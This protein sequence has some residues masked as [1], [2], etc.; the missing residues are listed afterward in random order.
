M[1]HVTTVDLAT[2]Q[3]DSIVND[4][5]FAD[6]GA[7]DF[8]VYMKRRTGIACRESLLLATELDGQYQKVANEWRFAS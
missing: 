2:S 3:Q 1:T 4:R 5:R 8:I 7:P 6:V